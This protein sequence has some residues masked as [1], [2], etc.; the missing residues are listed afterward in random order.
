MHKLEIL[1]KDVNGATFIGID[2]VTVVPL[3]GGKANPYRDRL[4]KVVTGSSVMVFQNK[5]TNGYENMVKRRLEQEGKDP[6]QFQLSPRVW[7]IR[8]QGQPFID[9]K[10]KVYLEVIFLKPGEVKYLLDGQVQIDPSTIPGFE[11]DKEEGKQG[12][13]DNKVIIRTYAVDSIKAVRIN[14]TK[15]VL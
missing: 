12:G 2:S 6:N 13:L 1:M 7:G 14:H 11:S 8:R 3:K 10:G 4:T 5:E 15:H 9:H